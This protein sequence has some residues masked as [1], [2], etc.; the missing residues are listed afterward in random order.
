[1]STNNIPKCIRYAPDTQRADSGLT[2]I[3]PNAPRRSN[4]NPGQSPVN[5]LDGEGLLDRLEWRL[6]HPGDVNLSEPAAPVFLAASDIGPEMRSD[7]T[8][9]F[10]PDSRAAN[11]S[12]ARP[13]RPTRPGSK[14]SGATSKPR[15]PTCSPSSTRLCSAP[16]SNVSAPATAP[17]DS[18]KPLAT[19]APICT[20]SDSEKNS[21]YT[22]F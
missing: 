3:Q 7:E 6:D 15:T 12:D 13:P 22:H 8:Q 14:R 18:M 5:A 1:M 2:T 21:G 9:T 16:N 4:H 11:T 20:R 10:M 19:C 17:P